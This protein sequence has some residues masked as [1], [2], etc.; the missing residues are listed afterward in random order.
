MEKYTLTAPE[1]V[2]AKLG[3]APSKSEM[4]RAQIL[5]TDL[6]ASAMNIDPDRIRIAYEKP[7]QFGQ[8]ILL[9]AS[10]D[11]EEIDD[12]EITVSNERGGTAVAIAP[13]GWSIGI[14]LSDITPSDESRKEMRRQS[15]LWHDADDAALTAHWTRVQAVL[16][17]ENRGKRVAPEFVKLDPT[18][19]RGW[20]PDRTIRYDL[21]DISGGGFTITLATAEPEE[22]AASG[23]KL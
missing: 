21:H 12:Y 17:A 5:A 10:V 20:V 22:A 3:W 11:G 8:H 6:I 7:A 15:Q 19:K 13:K 4:E 1:P 2:R 14:D 23:G 16:S 18:L 9:E